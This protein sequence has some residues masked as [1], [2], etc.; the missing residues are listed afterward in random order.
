MRRKKKTKKRSV[1]D[2]SNASPAEVA[3][4]FAGEVRVLDID[5]VTAFDGE[6]LSSGLKSLDSAI[7]VGGFPKGRIVEVFGPQNAGKTALCLHMIAKAQ[8]AGGKGG[9]IDVEHA[10]DLKHA[11]QCGVDV[12]SM[13]ISQPDSGEKAM[14]LALRL[15][16]AR[17]VTVLVVDSVAQLQPMRE[18]EK[19]I[20]GVTQP[21]TQAQLMSKSMR[22]LKAAALKNDVLLMFTNQIRYKIGVMFGSPETT[23]GGQALPYAADLR[24]RI[25]REKIHRKGGR[26]IGQNCEL[27]IVK[28][29]IGLPFQNAR[30][31]F[32][33]GKGWRSLK[34]K[35][36]GD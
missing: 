27:R 31:R 5:Q 20:D 16:T 24:I 26:V 23:P 10:L 9:I 7:G 8:Q 3:A 13:L 6:V 11:E 4:A 30:L 33:F 12:P 17:A 19:G 2:L 35:T 28:N 22:F 14:D 36:K 34:A 18:Q 32:V 29:K 21:G 25:S 15:I 1:E